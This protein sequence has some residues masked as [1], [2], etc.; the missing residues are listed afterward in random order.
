MKS[1]STARILLTYD[2]VDARWLNRGRKTL[3]EKR[4]LAIKQQLKDK[5]HHYSLVENAVRKVEASGRPALVAI[6]MVVFPVVR[7]QLQNRLHRCC[8]AHLSFDT[9]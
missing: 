9:L 2:F 6:S 8:L 3:E 1:A 7:E 4:Y 5:R